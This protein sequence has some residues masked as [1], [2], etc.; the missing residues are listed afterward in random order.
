MGLGNIL[1]LALW[2]WRGRQ[3]GLDT[4]FLA[5][6]RL[7]PWVE[8]FPRLQELALP[9][10]QVALGDLRRSARDT[11]GQFGE[12]FTR[13]ELRAFIQDVLPLDPAGFAAD[14]IVVN[15]RRGDYYSVPAIRGYFGFDIDAYLH[16]ALPASVAAQGPV[17]RI[18]VVSDGL[19][20][21]HARLGWMARFCDELTWAQPTD[22]PAENFLV[23]A[24]AERIIMT[25][26]TFS[27]WA[28]YLHDVLHPGM[29][30]SV[31]APSFFMRGS[32]GGRSHSLDPTWSIVPDI[33][34]GWDS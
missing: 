34:G 23:V 4:W 16:L 12:D 24:T 27:Y 20:W 11:F 9:Q 18:H 30:A 1:Y 31:W 13:N 15:V 5:T 28:G 17:S 25:N 6:H 22:T 29:E 32:E 3:Q 33:P 21:C 19:G 10:E 2:A 26:S 8:S 14:T 7:A